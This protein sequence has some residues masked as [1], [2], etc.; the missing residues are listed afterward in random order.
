M[1]SPE[2]QPLQQE[3]A[4]LGGGCFW[5]TEAV[6][7]A[8]AGVLAVE[9]GYCGGARPQ[10][11]YEQVC[12]GAT[13]HA[14]VVRISFD[15]SRIS[16]RELLAVFFATHDPTTLDRQGNDVGSQYRSVVFCQSP[17]QRHDAEALV[18][19][20]E[21]EQV[22]SL[23]IVTRIEDAAPY[24]PAEAYHQQYF[25]RNP[26]QPYCACLIPPKLDKL[27]H[28]FPALLRS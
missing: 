8:L 12:S 5:C 11:T 28:Y 20:L 14:E 22:F 25:E 18:A 13:G 7:R 4:I 27:Q 9:S 6:F 19:E 1:P 26:E 24:W 21:R 17:A 16:F 15:P 3:V 2:N 10:P 23:P